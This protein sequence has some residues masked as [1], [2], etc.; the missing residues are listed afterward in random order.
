[1]T[2]VSVHQDNASEELPVRLPMEMFLQQK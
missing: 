2:T 1:M